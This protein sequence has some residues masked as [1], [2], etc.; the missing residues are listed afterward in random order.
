MDENEV[1]APG[2][3]AATPEADGTDTTA[4]PSPQAP[5]PDPYA[6]IADLDPDE[7]LRRHPRL[8]GK[9]G[10][11]A[12]QQAQRQVAQL[13]AQQQAAAQAAAAEAEERMRLQ[14][15][16]HLAEQDPG[17][18][19]Q[20]IG[21]YQR[22]QEIQR[23]QSAQIDQARAQMAQEL[24]NQFNAV[25]SQPEI[26]QVIAETKDPAILEQLDWRRYP[27]VASYITATARVVGQHYAAREGDRLANERLEAL[28][29]SQSAQR[30]AGE[31]ANGVGQ[32]VAGAPVGGHIFS[33]DELK[34]MSVEDWRKHKAEVERQRQN[35]TLRLNE[36]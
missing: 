6:A 4:S 26:Q 34:A 18:L 5:P 29:R 33:E 25:Y 12:Q 21:N 22:Q 14:N 30:F 10:A 1:Q 8:Q 27:N 3:V 2:L 24:T 35:G 36:R 15:W 16:S 32:T 23:Q 19:S 7:L 20:E 9:L 13:Q 31:A 17:Q 28:R 11:L